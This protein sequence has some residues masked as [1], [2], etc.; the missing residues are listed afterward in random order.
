[1]ARPKGSTLTEKHKEAISESL[2]TSEKARTYHQDRQRGKKR[3]PFSLEWRAKMSV[4]R[5][6]KGVPKD[7]DIYKSELARTIARLDAKDKAAA[8]AAASQRA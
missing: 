5:R 6:F 2:R 8:A 7:S 4:S 1:M 3:E